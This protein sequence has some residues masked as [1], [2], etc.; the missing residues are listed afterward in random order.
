MA[1]LSEVDGSSEDFAKIVAFS[2]RSASASP[3]PGLE[4]FSGIFLRLDRCLSQMET[5]LDMLGVAQEPSPSRSLT[6]VGSRKFPGM[7]QQRS[8]AA[9]SPVPPVEMDPVWRVQEKLDKLSEQLDLCLPGILSLK[10][11]PQAEGKHIAVLPTVREGS[12]EKQPSAVSM[13]KDSAADTMSRKRAGQQAALRRGASRLSVATTIS[14]RSLRESMV[15]FNEYGKPEVV[16]RQMLSQRLR[17]HRQIGRHSGLARD[18]DLKLAWIGTGQLEEEDDA[19]NPMLRLINRK[20]RDM[21]WEALDDPQS[22]RVAWCISMSLRCIVLLSWFV[23]FLQVS[24]AELLLDRLAAAVLETVIDSIFLVEVLL[25]VLSA[26]SKT[27]YI[28]DLYNWADM[29]CCLGLPFRIAVGIPI[30]HQDRP[31]EIFLLFVLPVLRLLKLLRYFESFRILVDAASNVV[32]SLPVLLYVMVLLVVISSNAIYLAE[33]R[34]NIPSLQHS[35]WLAVVTMTTVGY[36]DFAPQSLPGYITVSFLSVVSV[37]F[38]ALPVGILGHEFTFCWQS[39]EQVLLLARARRA[40]AKWGY[41]ASDMKTLF[42]FA[43]ADGDGSLNLL[44]FYELLNQLRLG[45]D[46]RSLVDL[47]MMVDR[48]NSG[49]VDGFELLAKIFP[50]EVN[51]DTEQFDDSID[52]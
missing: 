51:K 49:S 24:E 15:A 21:I 8:R 17:R 2:S 16:S 48:D 43:D 34:E 35:V 19:A 39:R 22:G 25:R 31:F 14:T 20:W 12:M 42:E 10:S 11:Q 26:P 45:L 23:T 36:G 32:A 44:E 37:I 28:R 7:A 47:F 50:E 46:E 27:A 18:S 30:G 38:F 29:V 52:A 40:F 41:T 3:E 4:S 1:L 6:S 33:S 5:C 9:T 13:S